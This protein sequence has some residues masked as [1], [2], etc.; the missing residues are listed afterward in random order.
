MD[1][2]T[3]DNDMYKVEIVKN[4]FVNVENWNQ[5]AYNSLSLCMLGY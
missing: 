1:V 4:L 5:V 2:Y 3:N